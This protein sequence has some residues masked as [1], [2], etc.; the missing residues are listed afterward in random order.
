MVISQNVECD[1]CGKIY[2]TRIGVGHD[3]YQKHYFDCID[4]EQSIGVAVRANPPSA[5]IEAL[6]NCTLGGFD[7]SKTIINLHA[8]YCFPANKYHEAGYFISIHEGQRLFKYVRKVPGKFQG[9]DTQFDIP[10]AKELWK[11]VARI[12]KLSS[13]QDKERLQRKQINAY[14]LQRSKF[15][16][17]GCDCTNAEDVFLEFYDSMFYPRVNDISKPVIDLIDNLF[18][19][20]KL[21]EFH[22]FYKQNLMNEGEQ[23]YI[24]TISTYFDQRDILGQI[25]YRA[26]ISDDE[27]EDLVVGS[28]NFNDIKLYYGEVYEALTSQFTILACLNNLE[29]GRNYDQFLQMTLNK[30]IKDVEKSNKC[31]PFKDNPR[32]SKFTAGLD[33]SLRNGSHHASIWRENDIIMYK[34]GGTGAKR[35]IP[36][37][38]YLYQCNLLTIALVAL[39]IIELHIQ[40]K[41][42]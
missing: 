18:S 23:R 21:D 4:C 10:N 1:V 27:V 14:N 11:N 20:N 13:H 9:I 17:G 38:L 16:H 33:S 39:H 36:Y 35:A 30:Y 25:A 15:K 34:S 8:N 42:S 2:F 24:A 3:S 12:R 26:R 37:S 40:S 31:N 6:E 22:Y 28:K 32:F 29:A 19:N 41:Y 5:H 7:D